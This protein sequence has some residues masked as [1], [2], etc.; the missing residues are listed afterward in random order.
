MDWW[1]QQ[2]K[3]RVGRIG[4]AALTLYSTIWRRG[5]QW[6]C[7][8]TQGVSSTDSIHYHLEKRRPMGLLGV[9]GRE[10]H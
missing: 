10:Q 1:T 2:R 6:G 3:E 9:P 5:G 7:C 4:R 8:E